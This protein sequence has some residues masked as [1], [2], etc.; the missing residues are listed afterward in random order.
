MN[1]NFTQVFWKTLLLLVLVVSLIEGKAQNYTFSS[2]STTFTELAGSVAVNDI[3]ADDE[4]SASLP[5]GFTFNYFGTNF[6]EL[7][8]SSNGFLYLGTFPGAYSFNDW[9]VNINAIAPLWDDLS[10]ETTGTASYSTTGAAGSR[11]F[12]FEWRNWKWSY[13]ASSAS[14]SFQVKLY[15]T[16]NK[17]EFIYRREGGALS[18]PAASIGLLGS[19]SGEF[20]SL[21]NSTSSP[22]IDPNG[23]GAIDTKPASGQVYTF[24]VNAAIIG[25]PATA[26]SAIT[27]SSIG[28][29]T[30]TISWVNGNGSYRAV[31]IQQTS[32]AVFFTPVNGTR[33]SASSVYG[34]SYVGSDWYCIYNGTG[35]SVA[36]TNLQSGLPYRVQVI[37][38]NGLSGLQ[39]YNTDQVASAFTTLLVAPITPISTLTPLYVSS[40]VATFNLTEGN[41]LKRA[42]FMKAGTAGTATPVDNKTYLP[43]STFGS[44]EQIG[45]SG[46]YCVFNGTSSSGVSV[47]QLTPA[48][49]YSIHVVDYNG[50]A[51]QEKYFVSSAAGNPVLMT[52]FV[53]TPASPTYTFAATSGTFTPLSGGIPLN[54]IEEDDAFSDVIPIGFTFRLGGTPFT[55]FIASSNGYL[56]FNPHA[57]NFSSSENRNNDLRNSKIRPL[58]APLWDD[59]DGTDGQASYNTTGTAPNRILTLEFLNWQWPYAIGSA[60]I[61][62]QV[63]LYEANN[64][65][66]YIYQQESVALSGSP[67]AS[68]GLALPNLITFLSLSDVSTAPTMGSVTETTT[69]ATKPAT[70]QVYSFTPNKV[71]QTIAFGTLDAKVFGSGSFNLTAIAGSGLPVTFTS[72]NTS[73]ATVSGSTVTIIG[74]GTTNITASQQGDPGYNAAMDVI[75]PFVVVKAEQQLTLNSAPVKILGDAPFALNVT[76]SSS[77]PVTFS[78]T[79]NLVSLNG[80]QVTIVKDGSVTIYADQAGNANYNAA[81]RLEITFCINPVKPSITASALDTEAPVLTSSSAT[82][83]Q[84]FKDGIAIG[85]ATNATLTVSSVGLYTVVVTVDNCSSLSSDGESLIITGTEGT[86]TE[87]RIFPN[88]AEN[89][90]V[91]D[92]TGLNSPTP[93]SLAIYDVSGRTMHAMTGNGKMNVKV[94]SYRTGNYVLKIASGKRIITKQIIKK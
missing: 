7:N 60:T 2:S 79:S 36:V 85:G 30:S 64:K 22:S 89:E 17:I 58:V 86:E 23:F 53:S 62:F 5:I 19:T 67:S 13:A 31:F 10:G 12:T 68:V 28:S 80:S 26:A 81:G 6:T 90:I 91:V 21:S 32:S 82:G 37:E 77:L 69:I 46:W 50:S 15:E 20:Y 65:I 38:Y 47:A 39:M 29:L 92:V 16:T 25:A 74:A 70:G 14:I 94:S 27:A 1:K 63:K 3:E 57:L 35:N 52:T 93:V 56:T 55:E 73:V 34:D 51:G 59:L 43:S 42:I 40:T 9:T 66:E 72:S 49:T 54:T 8:A 44:G 11:I 41:G 75:Q 4:V 18:S 78:S 33:Y 24:T 48:T 45:T 61:S 88:P 87:V 76:A 84:W 71:N 83:N